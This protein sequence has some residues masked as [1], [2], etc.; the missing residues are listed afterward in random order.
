VY[1]PEKKEGFLYDINSLFPYGMKQDMPIG[2]PTIIKGRFN[3]EEI[4]KEKVGFAYVKVE[5]PN[6]QIPFLPYRNEEKGLLVPTGT[7]NG[8]YYS[9]EIKYAKTLGYK[10]TSL[11]KAYIF[12]KGKPLSKFVEHFYELKRTAKTPT[13]RLISKFILNQ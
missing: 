1:K 13:D 12:N 9:E 10:F 6:L 11:D 3:I 8:W 7:W 2:N 4:F 5:T